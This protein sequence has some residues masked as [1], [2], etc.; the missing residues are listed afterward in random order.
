MALLQNEKTIHSGSWCFWA[1]KIFSTAVGNLFTLRKYILQWVLIKR[2]FFFDYPRCAFSCY[3][4]FSTT[5]VKILIGNMLL[6]LFVKMQ[7]VSVQ[8]DMLY[9][10]L[11]SIFSHQEKILMCMK[12]MFRQNSKTITCCISALIFL[13]VKTYEQQDVFECFILG[14][15]K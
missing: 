2:N 14:N 3:G 15:V 4:H 1:L 13:L 9:L 11:V 10:N 12:C 8:Q 5:W 7:H 6:V